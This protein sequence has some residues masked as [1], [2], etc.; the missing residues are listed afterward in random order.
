MIRGSSSFPKLWPVALTVKLW[1]RMHAILVLRSS[2][3]FYTHGNHIFLPDSDHTVANN[4]RVKKNTPVSNMI[5][6]PTGRLMYPALPG[7]ARRLHG[8]DRRHQRV[9]SAHQPRLSNRSVES[10]ALPFCQNTGRS[11][12]RSLG[13]RAR[14]WTPR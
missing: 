1:L 14:K 13:P 7:P 5:T 3:S 10:L 2:M 8:G 11:Q 9:L 4:D 12:A 6:S